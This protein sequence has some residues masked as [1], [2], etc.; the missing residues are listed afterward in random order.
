MSGGMI[1]LKPV[2]MAADGQRVRAWMDEHGLADHELIDGVSTFYAM[3]GGNP[4]AVVQLQPVQVVSFN[5]DT[6]IDGPVSHRIVQAVASGCGMTGQ[7]AL[8]LMPKVAPGVPFL[9]RMLRPLGDEYAVFEVP[10]E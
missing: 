7:A 1:T 8:V 10:Q 4:V 5:I 2:D 6:S 9:Q 3:S